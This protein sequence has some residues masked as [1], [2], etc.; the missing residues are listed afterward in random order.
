ML[1]ITTITIHFNLLQVCLSVSPFVFDVLLIPSFH[2]L[3]SYFYVL[4]NLVVFPT[5]LIL[6]VTN[7]KVGQI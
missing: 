3:S 6:C 7:I 4:L 2:V 1:S 5:V